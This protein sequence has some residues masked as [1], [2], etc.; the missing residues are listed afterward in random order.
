MALP[1][2]K[3]KHEQRFGGFIIII[4]GIVIMFIPNLIFSAYNLTQF[5]Y[6]VGIIIGLIGLFYLLDGL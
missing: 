3:N 2:F 4:V 6:F 5:G 1:P